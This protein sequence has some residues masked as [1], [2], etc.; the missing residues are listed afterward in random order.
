MKSSRIVQ[1]FSIYK[2][3][4]EKEG[5]SSK[6]LSITT[7]WIEFSNK[8]KKSHALYLINLVIDLSNDPYEQET[9]NRLLGSIQ[10]IFLMLGIFNTEEVMCHSKRP[11]QKFNPDPHAT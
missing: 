9:I 5:L 3:L 8:E 2:E 1:I 6:R 4:L 11:A 10:T 7:K